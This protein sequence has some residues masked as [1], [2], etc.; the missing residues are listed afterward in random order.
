MFNIAEFK[1]LGL[2]HG[3][4]RPSLFEFMLAE[5][6]IISG[7]GTS[8]FSLLPQG[9]LRQLNF[10]ARAAK[11]PEGTVASISV[12]YLSRDIKVAG[13]M[14]F[15]D[16]EITI[17]N[18]EDWA[19]RDMFEAW[20]NTINSLE[21]NLRTAAFDLE[22]YKANFNVRQFAKEGSIVQSYQMVGA[23]PKLVSAI[24]LDWEDREKV[25]VFNVTFAIDYWLPD[26]GDTVGNIISPN[27]YIG[28]ATT[29]ATID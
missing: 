29:P 26:P 11:I 22:N 21:S 5:A 19:I 8:N 28:P 3:G 27:S 23:F 10:V 24:Q 25:E 9:I 14:T 7:A 2:I 20:Q 16:F 15:P 18:D 13:M 1:A 4:A 6:P 17:M 12:P